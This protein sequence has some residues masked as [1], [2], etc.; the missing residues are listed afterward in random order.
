MKLSAL[1]DKTTTVTVEWQGE[2]ADMDVYVGRL[3]QELFE[4]IT[5]ADDVDEVNE[6]VAWLVESWDIVDD[7]GNQLPADPTTVRRL[8]L[9]LI[10]A[11]VETMI[12]SGGDEGKAS[13]G[14]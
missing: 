10:R 9:G 11:L 7:D 4:E 3:T 12:S 8:P 13:R 2:T 14:G 1:R 5:A 6:S